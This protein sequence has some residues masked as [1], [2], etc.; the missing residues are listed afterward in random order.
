M[1]KEKLRKI[2]VD[3][4]RNPQ[5]MPSN[6]QMA[7]NL[8]NSVAKNVKSV[9]AGNSL[10]V[11]SDEANKRKNI[12][13]SCAFFNKSQERCTKCGCN[14]AIKTYLK[15]ERCPLGKW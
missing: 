7:K 1:D 9:I 10:K 15:A 2:L 11:S 13:N 14:M 5:T 3:G 12:C 8:A 4:V 6:F